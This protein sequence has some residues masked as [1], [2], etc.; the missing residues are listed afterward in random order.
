M[1]DEFGAEPEVPRHEIVTGDIHDDDGQAIDD[2]FE[3]ADNGVIQYS[4]VD[5]EDTEVPATSRLVSRT[6]NWTA[7]DQTPVLVLPADPYRIS[8]QI[9]AKAFGNGSTILMSDDKTHIQ[10][11]QATGQQGISGT[12]TTLFIPFQSGATA[13]AS[14]MFYFQGYTGPVWIAPGNAVVTYVSVTAVTQ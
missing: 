12:C 8:L 1:A 3:N 2:Y 14:E 5:I 6:V 13:V 10:A 11:M 4:G 9:Q 7:A